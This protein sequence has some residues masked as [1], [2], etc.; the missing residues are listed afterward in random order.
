MKVY[1]TN[2]SNASLEAE[3]F[4]FIKEV[5]IDCDY[6]TNEDLT[7]KEHARR[8]AEIHQFDEIAYKLII[9]SHGFKKLRYYAKRK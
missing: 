7:P 2:K 5:F 6:I 1:S 4:T 8:F 9:T 3:G